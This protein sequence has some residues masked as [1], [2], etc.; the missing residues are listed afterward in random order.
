MSRSE[1]RKLAAL[2]KKTAAKV[3]KAKPKTRRRYDD[4]LPP[5]K[6]EDSDSRALFSEMKKREF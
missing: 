1:D 4:T 5:E 2:V 6:E 3:A